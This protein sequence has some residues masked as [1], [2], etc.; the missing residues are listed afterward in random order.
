MQQRAPQRAG[1]VKVG[2]RC[3]PPFRDEI[4][5]AAADADD[6]EPFRPAVTVVAAHTTGGGGAPGGG[7]LGRLELRLGPLRTRAFD[8]DYAFG[9][10]STQD[11]VYE[12]LAKAEGDT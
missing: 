2:I 8:F 9:P 12:T 10:A 11:D 4:D 5:A 7:A 6:G 1:R 3:R